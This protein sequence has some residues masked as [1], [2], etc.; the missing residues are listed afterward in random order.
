MFAPGYYVYNP[1]FTYKWHFPLCTEELLH[2]LVDF[3]GCVTYLYTA[4]V[5]AEIAM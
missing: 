1:K 4:T 2:F 3:V 5:L